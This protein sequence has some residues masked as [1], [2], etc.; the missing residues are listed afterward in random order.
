MRGPTP[1]T[2]PFTTPFMRDPIYATPFMFA[3]PAKR[4]DDFV[5]H[6]TTTCAIS[7]QV[8]LTTDL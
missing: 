2:T 8:S 6:G 4:I 3:I 1:F 7:T 5:D